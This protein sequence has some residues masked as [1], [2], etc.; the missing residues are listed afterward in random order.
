MRNPRNA[1]GTFIGF[2]IIVLVRFGFW[3][4]SVY[5]EPLVEKETADVKNMSVEEREAL[6]ETLIFGEKGASRTEFRVGRAQCPLC[7][8]F[9]QELKPTGEFPRPSPPYG[10]HFFARFTERIEHLIASPE[11]RQ[12]PKGT[13]QPEAF[14][15]SGHA[16]TVIEY[17]AES[18]V[19][20]S[21]YVVPGF[22]VRNSHDRESPMPKIHKPPIGLTIDEMIAI[23][24]W[25]YIHEGKRPP[26]PDDI[27]NAYRKFIPESEW[28]QVAHPSR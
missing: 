14:P 4:L 19:C 28:E 10:P 12:R 9:F 1:V 17:L 8:D 7:H 27:E 24:T 18:N 6:G 20:P 23:D 13:A 26:S 11:Y 3:S 15:C 25:L 2:A 22:G 21:C 5:A 16:T